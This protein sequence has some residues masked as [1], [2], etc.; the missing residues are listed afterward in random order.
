MRA[1]K[2]REM[3]QMAELMGPATMGDHLKEAL[4]QKHLKPEDIDFAELAESLFG[5]EFTRMCDPAIESDGGVT[6]FFRMKEAE[7]GVDYTAFGTITQ[8]VI[9][10]KVVEEFDL[11]SSQA[12][13]M[14]DLETNVRLRHERRP[15]I[16][17]PDNQGEIVHPGMPYPRQGLS[18]KYQDFSDNNKRGTIIPITKEA[19]F[20]VGQSGEI[21]RQAGRVGEMLGI[22]KDRRI[23]EVILGINNNF[24]FG[25]RG[26]AV[27]AYNTYNAAAIAV[28]ND[29]IVPQNIH[30]WQFNDWND[31]DRANRLFDRMVDPDTGEPIE[32]RQFTLIVMPAR[33]FRARRILTASEVRETVGA[34]QTLSANPVS[35]YKLGPVSRRARSILAASNAFGDPDAVWLL[36]DPKKAFVYRENWP[37]GVLQAPLNAQAEFEQDIVFQVKA[38]ER[39]GCWVKRPHYMVVSSGSCGHSSSGETECTPDAWS[40]INA[41]AVQ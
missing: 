34:T 10:A 25:M 28:G 19:L 21:L 24:R 32:I 17:A 29:T 20:F 6:R 27:A 3:K 2:Y 41:N 7:D 35:A 39:G 26:N 5:R 40:A 31:I 36:G 4:E 16:T 23:W 13:G 33:E 15:G 11:E 38:S 37:L 1:I 30:G 12:A 22:N 18:E 9:S 14:V 8:R